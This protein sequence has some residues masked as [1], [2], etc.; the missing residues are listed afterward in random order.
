MYGYS[1]RAQSRRSCFAGHYFLQGLQILL[2][3]AIKDFMVKYVYIIHLLCFELFH[4]TFDSCR[5]Q[6]ETDVIKKKKGDEQIKV[7]EDC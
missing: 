1:D 6:S 3:P 2:P 5:I 7:Q 4:T